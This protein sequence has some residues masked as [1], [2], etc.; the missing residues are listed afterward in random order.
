M[1]HSHAI[2]TITNRWIETIRI[3]ADSPIEVFDLLH[4]SKEIIN[5]NLIKL[6][7]S[8]AVLQRNDVAL[9]LQN[10]TTLA[11]RI[12]WLYTVQVAYINREC[13]CALCDM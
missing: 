4:V 6:Q 11:I 12:A 3:K 13:V 7:G 8:K 2:G 5:V 10:T 9:K 1:R